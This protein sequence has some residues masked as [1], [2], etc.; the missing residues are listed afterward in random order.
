MK[1]LDAKGMACPKP[2]IETKK[3]LTAYPDDCVV[4]AVDNET[5]AE[6]LKK[7]AQSLGYQTKCTEK[8]KGIFEVLFT[9]GDIKENII[10][11]INEDKENI[12]QN[13]DTLTI[14]ISTNKLG[15]GDDELGLNLMKSYIYALTETGKNPESLIFLNSGVFF[16][17]KD[18]PVLTCLEELSQKGTEILSCGACLNF[19]NLTESLAVGSITNMYTIAEKMNNSTNT[20]KI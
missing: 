11:N 1:I 10:Q 19:Y 6:N 5:S 16:T 15:T 2:V 9:K 20:I 7:L 18:S 13:K 8:E 17:V 4:T 3:L 12:Q 14:I